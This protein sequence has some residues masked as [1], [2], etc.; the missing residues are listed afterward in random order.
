MNNK[1]SQ[2]VGSVTFETLAQSLNNLTTLTK[3]G[4]AVA[5]QR[6]EDLAVMIQQEFQE[7]RGTMNGRFDT[8]E[9]RV[10]YVENDVSDIKLKLDN[11][12]YRFDFK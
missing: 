9:E 8:L 5:E 3:Q 12:V 7:L 4:F 10:G 2:K 6:R 1:S 11:A